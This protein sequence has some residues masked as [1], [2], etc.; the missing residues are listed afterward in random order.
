MLSR[1]HRPT[2]GPWRYTGI[3]SLSVWWL[4][5]L[6]I[7][8][9]EGVVHD[10]TAAAL[11]EFGA[12]PLVLDVLVMVLAISTGVVLDLR[13]QTI[14]ARRCIDV[15]RQRLA[16]MKATMT[17]VHDIV[18]NSLMHLQWIRLEATEQLSPEVLDRFDQI[19]QDTAAQL[20]AL[21]DVEELV[22]RPFA[23]GTGV[24]YDLA[25]DNAR[26]PTRLVV[27]VPPNRTA[28]R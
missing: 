16:A 21:S 26:V 22:D 15:K 8:S 18:N 25:S 12:H 14:E 9:G 13:R 19:I 20:R 27:E 2:V 4:A 7:A 3:A 24:A 23:I 10:L 6:A 5:T 11:G 28:R 1:L 17:T